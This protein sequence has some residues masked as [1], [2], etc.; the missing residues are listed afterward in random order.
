M[1]AAS[2]SGLIKYCPV[3][4]FQSNDELVPNTHLLFAKLN[5]KKQFSPKYFSQQP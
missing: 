4:F 3:G 2:Q 5:H 1:N